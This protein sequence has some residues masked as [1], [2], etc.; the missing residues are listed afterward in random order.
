MN[1]SENLNAVKRA[2]SCSTIYID[3]STVSQPNL[4][5]AIRL[6]ACAIYYHIKQRK[7]DRTM[8][9]FDEKL[10]PI[11]VSLSK[12]KWTNLFKFFQIIISFYNLI[13]CFLQ[14]DIIVSDDY[15]KNIPDQR[16]IYKFMKNLF[17]AA[18][19]TAECAIVTLVRK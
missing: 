7:S 6:V 16:F 8:D 3:D 18:Q 9:I 10:Y 5:S 4:K 14:K 11:S 12:N 19:L 2:N 13:S 15:Y 1:S 17:T